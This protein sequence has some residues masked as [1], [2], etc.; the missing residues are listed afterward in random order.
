MATDQTWF[1][2]EMQSNAGCNALLTNEQRLNSVLNGVGAVNYSLLHPNVGGGVRCPHPLFF[3]Y[4]L[5]LQ[6]C[7]EILHPHHN[8]VLCGRGNFTKDHPGNK[9]FRKIVAEYKERCVLAS[10]IDKPPFAKAVITRVRHLNPPGRF[11]RKGE[12]EFGQNPSLYYEI[13]NKEAI[14]KAAQALRENAK[15]LRKRLLEKKECETSAKG[16]REDDDDDDCDDDYDELAPIPFSLEDPQPPLPRR[17]ENETF[18]PKTTNLQKSTLVQ[19]AMSMTSSCG[20]IPVVTHYSLTPAREVNGIGRFSSEFLNEIANNDIQDSALQRGGSAEFIYEDIN[21]PRIKMDQDWKCNESAVDGMENS[22]LETIG[23]KNNHH[24]SRSLLFNQSKTSFTVP[25]ISTGERSSYTVKRQNT[26]NRRNRFAVRETT[27][28]PPSHD[29]NSG[30]NQSCDKSFDELPRKQSNQS[31]TMC[32]KISTCS[33]IIEKDNDLIEMFLPD[34]KTDESLEENPSHSLDEW[35]Q[36]RRIPNTLGRAFV[37]HD[38]GKAEAINKQSLN[39][40]NDYPTFRDIKTGHRV[41]ARKSF[42]GSISLCNSLEMNFEDELSA[43]GDMDERI[44][45]FIKKREQGKPSPSG[46]IIE[47]V[48]KNRK[49]FKKSKRR[50]DCDS[51]IDLDPK[52]A[53]RGI[54][55]SKFSLY[56][57]YLL[58]LKEF[59]SS[60]ISNITDNDVSFTHSSLMGSRS[61]LLSYD[62]VECENLLKISIDSLIREEQREAR[63]WI[64][65][66][67][68]DEKEIR[69]ED[70]T[71]L[72]NWRPS[73][74]EPMI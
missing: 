61:F 19:S 63:A 11:L 4:G 14:D 58:V 13:G 37:E 49:P 43:E 41:P 70:M 12:E 44:D 29:S 72:Y 68:T 55:H 36:F 10:K 23:E 60:K 9:M 34:Y 69:E 40:T 1:D 66:A 2:L 33:S 73:R 46:D 52:R 38:T 50:S 39:S 27:K 35:P 62:S 64:G 6:P 31:E 22:N 15:Q 20:G 30:K 28:C 17:N 3:P 26:Q 59:S 48:F 47:D 51:G 21:H 24:M 7:N 42:I 57:S 8:D 56:P 32:G 65:H 25:S 74:D 53:R 45:E 71:E 54:I 5:R 16:Q 67:G 18:E